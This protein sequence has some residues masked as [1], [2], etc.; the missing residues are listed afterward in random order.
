MSNI[1]KCRVPY[2]S[3]TAGSSIRTPPRICLLFYG[4]LHESMQTTSRKNISSF[5]SPTRRTRCLSGYHYHLPQSHSDCRPANS[6]ISR[7]VERSTSALNH[8][9]PITP[10]LLGNQLAY[11]C[12]IGEL[13]GAPSF[14][15]NLLPRIPSILPNEPLPLPNSTFLA[16]SRHDRPVS[17][18]SLTGAF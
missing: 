10:I 12:V 14:S 13:G 11:T 1:L 2:R 6:V 18:L 3:I 8:L 17:I 5:G 7:I 9:T 15:F 16:H 4:N